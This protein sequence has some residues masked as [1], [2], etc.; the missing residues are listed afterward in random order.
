MAIIIK[1][2][3][4][5]EAIEPANGKAFTLQELQNV[6]GGYIELIPIHSGDY[7]DMLLIVNEEGLLKPNPQ[8]NEEASKIAGRRI[9]GQVIIVDKKQIK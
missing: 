1:I 9:V 8:L 7:A 5:H 4:E 6:V 2:S 3:G